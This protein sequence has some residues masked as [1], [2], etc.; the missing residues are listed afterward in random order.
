M[1]MTSLALGASGMHRA[2]DRL[3]A[4]ATRIARSGTDLEGV[5]LA[6]EMVGI[7][8]AKTSFSASAKVVT[9]ADQMSKSLLDILV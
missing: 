3:D 7:L 6:R 8:E 4:S 9:T 1:T 2:S 5:D